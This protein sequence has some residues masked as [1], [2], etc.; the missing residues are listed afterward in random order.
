MAR[1]RGEGV[2]TRSPNYFDVLLD[3]LRRPASA[4]ESF[5]LAKRWT[6][7]RGDLYQR[8]CIQRYAVLKGSISMRLRMSIYGLWL[9]FQLRRRKSSVLEVRRSVRRRTA[10]RSDAKQ[11]RHAGGESLAVEEA[12]VRA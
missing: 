9:L 3:N 4:S 6:L 5:H 11:K 2:R 7:S 12:G 8:P 1:A 10:D